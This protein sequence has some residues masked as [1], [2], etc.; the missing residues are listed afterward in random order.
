[1]YK[2]LIIL[3]LL[4]IVYF[5]L[6]KDVLVEGMN[7]IHDLTISDDLF[8]NEDLEKYKSIILNIFKNINDY[9]TEEKTIDKYLSDNK[10]NKKDYKSIIKFIE[11]Q[12]NN[13]SSEI[14]KNY[15]L[16]E[17]SY[18]NTLKNTFHKNILFNIMNCSIN[19]RNNVEEIFTYIISIITDEQYEEYNQCS[20]QKF[21]EYCE[22]NYSKLDKNNQKEETIESFAQVIS[23]TKQL[24]ENNTLIKINSNSNIPNN[25]INKKPSEKTSGNFSVSSIETIVLNFNENSFGLE[26]KSILGDLMKKFKDKYSRKIDNTDK[27]DFVKLVELY[28]IDLEYLINEIKSGNRKVL[29]EYILKR[30][31][32][33][34]LKLQY[35]LLSN[36]ILITSLVKNPEERANAL[37]CCQKEDKCYNF[38]NNEKIS[39]PIIYGFPD[40]GYVSEVK[41]R[42]S[43]NKFNINLES[44]LEEHL[45][46]KFNNWRKINESLKIEIYEKLENYLK[47]FN[48][49]LKNIKN[50]S[51]KEIRNS[52]SIKNKQNLQFNLSNKLE[53]VQNNINEL[54][55]IDNTKDINENILKSTSISNINN[56]LVSN[57]IDINTFDL[58]SVNDLETVK[59]YAIKLNDLNK[60]FTNFNVSKSLINISIKNV[61]GLIESKESFRIILSK[62]GILNKYHQIVFDKIIEII[63]TIKTIKIDENINLDSYPMETIKYLTVIFPPEKNNNI[64][65]SWQNNLLQMRKNRTITFEEYIEYKN[66]IINYCNKEDILESKTINEIKKLTDIKNQYFKDIKEIVIRY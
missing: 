6:F 39:N 52:I 20:P 10:V 2:L 60:L 59:N 31:V 61:L 56:Y 46:N 53:Y 15:I 63:R 11:N 4:G 55:N 30:T 51:I 41:C 13:Y 29:N 47:Y 3:L 1:M 24:I 37:L 22:N 19:D 40:Y 57:G 36:Y 58:N 54:L 17:K 27:K 33:Y 35:I 45:I 9:N 26:Y 64:C 42:S 66:K 12:L 18:I 43:N 49:T 50:L 44:K 48:M 38:S 16:T 21:I 28:I 7:C 65:H 14:N 25:V 8:K 32:F 5:C 62:G 34:K 23:D